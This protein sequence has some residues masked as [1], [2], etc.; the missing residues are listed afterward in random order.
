VSP[1]CRHQLVWLKAEAWPALA[2]AV[3]ND[4]ARPALAHW[5][6]HDL[7]LVMARQDEGSVADAA[8]LGLPLPSSWGRQRLRFQVPR[9]LFARV[10]HFPYAREV[11]QLVAETV[12]PAFIDL[13]DGL[14]AQGLQPRVFGSY[15]WQHLT[16]LDHVRDGSDL[17][18]LVPLH[19]A[20]SAD[21]AE[22]LMASFASTTLRLDGELVFPDGSA[23]AWREWR[24]WRS[25][26]VQHVLLKRI[27]GVVLAAGTRWL[28]QACAPHLVSP[29]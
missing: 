21:V 15:G 17:D 23:L 28:E 12:R 13:C 2:A 11:V 1:H 18:L 25:A 26:Q 20:R 14:A 8:A 19:D 3:D 4:A 7:P 6:H 9:A 10:D 29:Q 16:G 22:R 27:D 24:P 5:A